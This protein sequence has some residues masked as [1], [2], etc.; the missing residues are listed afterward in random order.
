MDMKQ[1]KCF[2][3][4]V[5]AGNFTRASETMHIAQ[6]AFSRHISNLETELG[7]QL[8]IRKGRGIEL[9]QE[10]ASAY[11]RAR[12]LLA[13]FGAFQREMA[14][15][16]GGRSP[17]KITLAAHGGIGQL[18][19]PKVARLVRLAE[20]VR[21]NL[22]E[23]LSERIERHVGAGECD[24]GIVIRRAGFKVERA[25]L[26]TVKLLDDHM[27]A[28]GTSGDGG[29]V[30]EDWSAETILRQ[31]LVLAPSGSLERASV[32]NWARQHGIV[33]LDILGEAAAVSARIELAR[34]I[35]AFCIL[36]G[37]G[38]VDLLAGDDWQIHRVVDDDYLNGLEWFVVY[39]RTEGDRVILNIV[40]VMRRQA[41]ALLDR[42]MRS[43]H[44]LF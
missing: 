7:V 32:E 35:S 6:S 9:S 22:K 18:F 10:G 25:D 33:A 15:H 1:L 43:Y 30:G 23:A 34:Q 4:A 28:V 42:S 13:D 37:I 24:I 26:E 2:A 36:P 29:L 19:L 16:E 41:T 3:A 20:P 39:R 12:K 14:V 27:F 11:D 8:F 40:D 38:L 17:R 44:Y 21:F 5:E 31:P